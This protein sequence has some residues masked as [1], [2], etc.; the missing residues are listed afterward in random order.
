MKNEIFSTSAE[1]LEYLNGL[2]ISVGDA[3]QP[4]IAAINSAQSL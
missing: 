4:T 1:L 3:D 2:V